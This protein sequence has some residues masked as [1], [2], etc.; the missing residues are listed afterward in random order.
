[1]YEE[2]DTCH[3]N[4]N[5][6]ISVPKIR[7]RLVLSPPEYLQRKPN[8]REMSASAKKYASMTYY[9]IYRSL[10]IWRIHFF[11]GRRCAQ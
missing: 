4:N 8:R 2:R 10:T 1:M 3:F 11:K 7:K 6:R 5:Y 9:L